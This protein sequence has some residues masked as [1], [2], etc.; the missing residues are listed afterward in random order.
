MSEQTEPH[1]HPMRKR[2]AAILVIAAGIAAISGGTS[3]AAGE[4]GAKEPDPV[5]RYRDLAPDM[6]YQSPNTFYGTPAPRPEPDVARPRAPQRN[7]ERDDDIEW[8][9][10]DDAGDGLLPHAYEDRFDGYADAPL[11]PHGKRAARP[12]LRERMAAR[13][14]PGVTVRITVERRTTITTRHL[15]PRRPHHKRTVHRVVRRTL[16][17]PC[18]CPVGAHAVHPL[19]VPEAPPGWIA[20]EARAYE[21][22]GGAWC[23][24]SAGVGHRM[25]AYGAFHRAPV[26]WSHPMW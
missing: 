8:L 1:R 7:A 22:R 12:S 9:P 25:P 19:E 11:A 23:P 18:P 3:A 26:R 14:E 21:V 10:E 6:D 16:P 15:A 4:P 13:G 24:E 20:H 2:L 17:E 5:T